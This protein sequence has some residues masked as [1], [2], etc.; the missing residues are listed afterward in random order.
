MGK[1]IYWW[2]GKC[3]INKL[4][5]MKDKVLVTAVLIIAALGLAAYFKSKKSADGREPEF[6]VSDGLLPKFGRP[7][8][9]EN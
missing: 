5:K 7:E 1:R 4:V 2:K 3:T 8:I 9:L 6:L